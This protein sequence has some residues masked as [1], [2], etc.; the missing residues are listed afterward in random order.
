MDILSFKYVDVLDS[1]APDGGWGGWKSVLV[2]TLEV[3]GG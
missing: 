3:P 2:F 1:V